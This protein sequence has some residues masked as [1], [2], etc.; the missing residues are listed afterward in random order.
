MVTQ[1]VKYPYLL[2]SNYTS[3]KFIELLQNTKDKSDKSILYKL[4]KDISIKT[5]VIFKIN[6][7][8]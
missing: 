2:G 1:E 8:K 7:Q 5:I 4:N 3:E 6:M